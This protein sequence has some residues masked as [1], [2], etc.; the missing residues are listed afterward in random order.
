MA[1]SDPRSFVKEGTERGRGCLSKQY[2][3][4]G[5]QLN[6]SGQVHRRLSLGPRPQ[7]HPLLAPA[8]AATAAQR[9]T[10][11]FVALGHVLVRAPAASP[12]PAAAKWKQPQKSGNNPTQPKSTPQR[13]RCVIFPEFRAF[14]GQ[15][16]SF[17]DPSGPL[18]DP[19][20]LKW[21]VRSAVGD[22]EA[23]CPST[24]YH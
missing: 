11:A 2:I 8:A 17:G 14:G 10:R 22:Q 4:V 19:N 5:I 23:C 1:F 24:K 21:P 18:C 16:A 7:A 15:L 20:A 3:S 12:R 9:G 13:V 6:T